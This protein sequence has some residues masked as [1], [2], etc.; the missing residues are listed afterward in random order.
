MMNDTSKTTPV[1]LVI[2]LALMV[3]CRGALH[4]RRFDHA[5]M[6]RVHIVAGN[7]ALDRNR[8]PGN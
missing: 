1:V 7:V 8:P 6:G 2:G 4:E 3:L 5:G